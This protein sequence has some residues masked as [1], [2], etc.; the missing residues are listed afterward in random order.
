MAFQRVR[1]IVFLPD[2]FQGET[3]VILLNTS[4]PLEGISLG[5]T[6]ITLSVDVL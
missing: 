2:E 6:G 5:K 3:E 4:F 1:L